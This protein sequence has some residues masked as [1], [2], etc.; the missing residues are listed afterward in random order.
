MLKVVFAGAK[1]A[2]GLPLNLPDTNVL[3]EFMSGADDAINSIFDDSG[4]EHSEDR[5]ALREIEPDEGG[6]GV[7]K[8]TGKA[9]MKLKMFFEDPARM[10]KLTR[11]IDKVRGED[12]KEEWVS[13]RK[14]DDF[15]AANDT[16]S[17]LE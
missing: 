1:L 13:I 10:K 8:I 2:T 11:A 3:E 5:R 7:K 16:V 14:L 9:Y 4:E 6:E 12:R 17:C 15:C